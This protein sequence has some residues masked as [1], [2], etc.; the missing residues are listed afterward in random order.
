MDKTTYKIREKNHGKKLYSAL[1]FLYIGFA[2]KDIHEPTK[3][4]II[5]DAL[6]DLQKGKMTKI[7]INPK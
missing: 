6:W 3:L 1:R 2:L 4:D 7:C 5:N